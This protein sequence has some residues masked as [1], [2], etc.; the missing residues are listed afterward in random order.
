M[1]LMTTRNIKVP[2]EDLVKII[3]YHMEDEGF[4][5]PDEVIDID[6]GYEVDENGLVEFEVELAD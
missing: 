2:Y 1:S 6:L 5:L 3:T 4:V